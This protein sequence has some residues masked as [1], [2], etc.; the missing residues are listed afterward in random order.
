MVND[1]RHVAVYA[2]PGMMSQASINEKGTISGGSPG[3]LTGRETNNV[4][5]RNYP[6]SCY[7][8]YAAA[9]SGEPPARPT[10]WR[11]G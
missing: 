11:G 6:W 2:T 5:H 10:S 9:Q 7:L 1:G 8:R 3:E 4:A